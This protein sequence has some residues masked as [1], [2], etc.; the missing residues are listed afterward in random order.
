MNWLACREVAKQ[1]RREQTVSL[2]VRF[3]ISGSEEQCN[4]Y[5]NP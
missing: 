2:G 5:N 1:G 3:M 4:P